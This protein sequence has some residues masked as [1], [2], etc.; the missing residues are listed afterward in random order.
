MADE[1][2][3]A[4]RMNAR[5]MALQYG[6]VWCLVGLL[7]G[8]GAPKPKP[9]DQ[10]KAELPTESP[11]ASP[12]IIAAGDAHT[13]LVNPDKT[14][15]CWGDNQYGQ[16][17]DGT[18]AAA[19][20]PVAVAHLAYVAAVAAGEW[21]TCAALTTGQVKCWGDNSLWQ[22]G[23]TTPRRSSTPVLSPVGPATQ[24]AAGR[25]HT[26]AILIDGKVV[27]WGDNRTSQTG[28]QREPLA[29]PSL[30]VIVPAVSDAIA[31]AAGSEHSCAVQ[32]DG[33]LLCWGDNHFGQLGHGIMEHHSFPPSPV[34]LTGKVLAVA[35]GRRHTCALLQD[36]T[37]QCWGKGFEGQLGDGL[38][39]DSLTPVRVL[40]P[41]PAGK[42]APLAHV[43]AIT[44]GSQHTCALLEN[45]QVYC[46]GSNAAGQ[47]GRV[48]GAMAAR[49]VFSQFTEVVAVAAG[50]WHTCALR[51]SGATTCVGQMEPKEGEEQ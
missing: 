17:G 37:V 4:N 13:C 25:T 23:V 10:A 16:L 36:R 24:I 6:V 28:V 15:A 26:C 50:G 43:A 35:A 42:T 11:A 12:T 46:W 20:A 45:G 34:P 38:K 44:A 30:P 47:L 39:K 14:A 8:C 1:H 48:Q 32:K 49:P 29:K 31:I 21:H 27:C 51:A 18:T 19:K 41:E 33:Q 22:L 7:I 2:M 5:V 9:P 3:R 40:A